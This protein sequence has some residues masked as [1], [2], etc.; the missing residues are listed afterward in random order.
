MTLLDALLAVSAKFCE[1]RGISAARTS[2][3]VFGDGK[4]LTRLADGRDLTTRRLELAMQWF[5]DH[6]PE[7][8][9]VW[10]DRVPRPPKS[11]VAK[12][13]PVEGA[14]A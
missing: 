8:K 13:P 14:V 1:A 4:V 9:A 2:T 11:P 5:S 6:W 12:P 10:P 3:L 7:D